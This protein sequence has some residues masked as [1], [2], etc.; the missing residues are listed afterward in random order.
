MPTLVVYASRHG[1]TEACTNLLAGKLPGPV[2]V[3]NL[4]KEKVPAPDAYD[5][6]LIGGSIHMGQVQKTVAAFCR[7]NLETL[8]RKKVGLFICCGNLEAVEQQMKSAYPEPL[9]SHAAAREHFGYTYNFRMMNF[10]ERFIIKKIAKV[11]QSVENYLPE[12][13]ER[14]VATVL[15]GTTNNA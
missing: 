13:I 6:V 3:V 14:F 15:Q 2:T 8:L 4:E 10:W 1:C 9:Y 11:N 12:N 7:N 5:T